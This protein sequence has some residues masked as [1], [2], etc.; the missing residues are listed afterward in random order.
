[1]SLI[2]EPKSKHPHVFS[3]QLNTQNCIGNDIVNS[4]NCYWSFNTVNSE[5]CGY[6]FHVDKMK[7]CYDT[8]VVANSE[9]TYECTPGYDLYDC[10]FCLVPHPLSIIM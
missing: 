7:D 9:L 1:M 8:E 10:N 3:Q 2:E 6:T 5:D 4:K